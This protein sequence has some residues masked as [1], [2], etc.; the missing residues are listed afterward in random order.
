MRVHSNEPSAGCEALSG[1][2]ERTAGWTSTGCAVAA[3]PGSLAWSFAVRP[4]EF[5]AGR[6]VLR[7]RLAFVVNDPNRPGDVKTAQD[8]GDDVSDHLTA[9]L[10]ALFFGHD[11]RRCDLGSLFFHQRVELGIEPPLL[12]RLGHG[13]PQIVFLH[14]ILEIVNTGAGVF[15]DITERPLNVVGL[16]QADGRLQVGELLES[17]GLKALVIGANHFA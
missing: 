6:S 17:F 8:G 12:G 4:E 11:R 3:A 7:K 2:G 10:S 1:S 16:K 14:K 5:P 15:V 9:S 13:E